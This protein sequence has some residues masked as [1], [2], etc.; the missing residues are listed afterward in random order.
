MRLSGDQRHRRQ[1]LSL[2]NVRNESVLV[3]PVRSNASTLLAGAPIA[4]LRRRLKFASLFFDR[5]ILESGIFKVSAGPTGASAFIV[6]ADE[7]VPPRWQTPAQRHA[8]IG[9]R[10]TVAFSKDPPPDATLLPLVSSEAAISWVAT[11]HPFANELPAGTDWVDFGTPVD[12]S[13][14]I[15]ELAQ[16]WA[17]EDSRNDALRRAVPISFVRDE[18]IKSANHDLAFTAAAG[19]AVTLDP[20]HLQVAAQ[21]FNDENNWKFQG[22]AVP[23]LFPHVGDLSWETIRDLRRDPNMARFRAELQDVEDEATAE[24]IG[25]DIEGAAEHAYRRHLAAYS[26][27][28]PNVGAIAHRTL[29]G[30]VVGGVAGFAVSGITGP[31]GTVAGAA[32]GV[33]ATTVMDIREVIRGRRSRGWVALENRIQALPRK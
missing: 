33:G 4:A 29:N 24:A 20:L 28:L 21:R 22:F 9:R 10:F 13:G 3:V 2:C 18:I 27:T 5:L 15:G 7:S 31:L 12:P 11:L 19:Y 17:A 6:P 25:G 1:G 8:L 32:L 14:E 16:R 26:E 23:I 30:F